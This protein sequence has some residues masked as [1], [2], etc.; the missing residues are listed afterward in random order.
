MGL[1]A[2]IPKVEDVRTSCRRSRER[3]N[4]RLLG[5]EDPEPNRL[6]RKVAPSGLE[7]VVPPISLRIVELAGTTSI[8]SY[9]DKTK[10]VKKTCLLSQEHRR[11]S[12]L[13]NLHFG[14]R[15]PQLH[16]DQLGLYIFQNHDSLK[17]WKPIPKPAKFTSSHNIV[18]ST[19]PD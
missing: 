8:I 3:A 19:D 15:L 12:P 2:P 10:C 11:N 7:P 1:I 9:N 4:N 14:R 17:A 5:A 6:S 13:L 16:P 18:P